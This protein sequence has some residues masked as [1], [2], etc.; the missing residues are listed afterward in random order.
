MDQFMGTERGTSSSL[1]RGGYQSPLA[2][3]RKLT[4]SFWVSEIRLF[5]EGSFSMRRLN[6]WRYGS[7]PS[8]WVNA[9]GLRSDTRFRS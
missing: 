9:I 4:N 5:G 8:S 6:C 3:P 2:I 1:G 7:I